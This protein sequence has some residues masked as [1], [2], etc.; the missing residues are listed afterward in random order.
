MLAGGLCAGLRAGARSA[1]MWRCRSIKSPPAGSDEPR[2]GSTGAQDASV[3]YFGTYLLKSGVL[4]RSEIEDA[5]QARV[6]YG[7]RLGT[8]L[9]ELG[10]LALDELAMHLAAYSGV[11]L[12][13]VAKLSAPDPAALRAVPLELARRFKALAYAQQG[14]ALHVAMLD[15]LDEAQIAK[16][17]QATGRRIQPFTVPEVLL[18]ML[19]EQHLSIPQERRFA[20]LANSLGAKEALR[21]QQQRSAPAPRSA[22]PEPR[23]PRPAAVPTPLA[24][25]EELIDEASFAR[26]H[27]NLVLR[28]RSASGQGAAGDADEILLDE[29]APDTEAEVSAVPFEAAPEDSGEVARLETRIDGAADRDEIASLA[30]RLARAYA[31]TAALFLVQGGTVVGLRGDSSAL[32]RRIQGVV[33]PLETDCQLA[34]VAQTREPWRGA[35]PDGGVDARILRALGRERAREMVLLPICIRNRVVNVL[36][37]DNG[38][39][40]IGETS[41]AALGAL[42]NCVSRAYQRLILA[43]KRSEQLGG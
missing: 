18:H 6:V 40:A 34:R 16:L 29:V 30:V 27:E 4:K 36:Y 13:P 31:G 10:Y 22:A 42:C 25:G 20:R 9:L 15:P 7:G 3:S 35:P 1:R 37:A 2:G 21:R 38:F 19:L 8:N 33:V 41:L 11:P 23:A 17:A 14:D 26:L 43:S 5:L 24:E 28:G 32:E 39:E 12:A